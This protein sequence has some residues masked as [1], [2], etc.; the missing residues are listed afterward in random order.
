MARR[1]SELSAFEKL[2]KFEQLNPDVVRVQAA[3]VALPAGER[4]KCY[5]AWDLYYARCKQSK[6]AKVFYML[7]DA[8]KNKS[9]TISRIRSV[10][11]LLIENDEHVIPPTLLNPYEILH[12]ESFVVHRQLIRNAQREMKGATA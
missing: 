10:N 6:A 4:A 2:R 1:K 9:K 7:R 3:W 11:R 5:R 8:V 12:K